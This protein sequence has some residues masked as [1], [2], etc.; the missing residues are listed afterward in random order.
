MST[1]TRW[2]KSRK[3]QRDS[4]NVLRT[5]SI[6]LSWSETHETGLQLSAVQ[7]GAQLAPTCVSTQ[8]NA[9]QDK[10]FDA[11]KHE[12]RSR[13]SQHL[14]PCR[15]PRTTFRI[16]ALFHG[17]HMRSQRRIIAGSLAI[18]QRA[19]PAGMSEPHD[20]NEKCG[21]VWESLVTMP[22][23]REAPARRLQLQP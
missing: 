8:V 10:H 9:Q 14:G 4:I 12:E 16:T 18:A 7:V 22:S 15:A 13:P 3:P 1:R 20:F 23:V 21:S 11:Q 2:Q 17:L 19:P 5:P 6:Q